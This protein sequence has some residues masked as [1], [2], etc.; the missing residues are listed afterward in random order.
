MFPSLSTLAIIAMALSIAIL[1]GANAAPISPIHLTQAVSNLKAL[2]ADNMEGRMPNTPGHERAAAFISSAFSSI[3]LKSFNTDYIHHFKYGVGWGEGSGSNIIGWLEG[4]HLPATYFVISAHYDHLGKRGRQI[5][6]G[7]DDNASGVA[8]L[9][10]L[11]HHFS[12]N[13][14]RHSIIFIATDAEEAGLHGAEAFLSSSL[15]PS[16]HIAL[17]INIDMIGNG[18]SRNELYLLTPRN[19]HY[20]S[21]VHDYVAVN[22]SSKFRLRIG[23]P[24]KVDRESVLKRKIDWRKAGD[25]A[26]FLKHGINYIYLGNDVHT[27]YH[28]PSDTYEN[29]DLAFF[30]SSL[31]HITNL[32]T[33]LDQVMLKAQ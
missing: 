23:Q 6:N 28:K 13:T 12:V 17:N 31:S 4:S 7:A 33:Q 21:V 30:K 3:T 29:I 10:A 18:G 24:R 1:S 32:A 22:T 20:N 5:Y 16:E 9:L 26:A 11:A 14:P 25:H 15:I 8:A 2:S 27:H 19:T